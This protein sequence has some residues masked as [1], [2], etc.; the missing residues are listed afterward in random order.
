MVICVYLVI[1]KSD[2]QANIPV[3]EVRMITQID[4]MVK[5]SNQAA[6][7]RLKSKYTGKQSNTHLT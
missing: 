1:E 2:R 4:A 3:S 6:K 7:R 5:C